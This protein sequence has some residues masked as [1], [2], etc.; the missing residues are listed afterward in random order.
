MRA[1]HPA[2]RLDPERLLVGVDERHYHGSRG[3][4][5]RAKK[6]EAANKISLARFN[7]FTSCSSSRIRLLSLLVVPGA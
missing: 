4:S 2:D 1:Q 5:S 6:L 3:S 7:S